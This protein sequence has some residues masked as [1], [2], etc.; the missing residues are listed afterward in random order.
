MKKTLILAMVLV[1]TLAVAAGCSCQTVESTPS[2]LS[3]PVSSVPSITT[4]SQTTSEIG[5][6]FVARTFELNAKSTTD[7]VK[8]KSLS[9]PIAVRFSLWMPPEWTAAEDTTTFTDTAG[10]VVCEVLAPV[11]LS[12]TQEL[13]DVPG[14]ND[15]E[16][17]TISSTADVGL[18]NMRGKCIVREITENSA[19]VYLYQYFMLDDDI[20]YRVTFR[21]YTGSESDKN[22]FNA[23]MDR[24][25]NGK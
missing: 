2:E 15:T 6:D 25:V 16:N 4:P 17:G 13:P 1:L 3:V 20:V 19:T 14:E 8:Y 9:D 12:D 11:M 18:S 21:S 7:W 23:V 10:R 5:D 22:L 24:L